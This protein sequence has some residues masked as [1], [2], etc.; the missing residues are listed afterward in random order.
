MNESF[1]R[2]KKFLNEIGEFKK[3][4]NI[5]VK[6]MINCMEKV[7]EIF[8]R[9]AESQDGIS[10]NIKGIVNSKLSQG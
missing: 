8:A 6:S 1:N 7:I 2:H 5:S 4:K 10:K 3:I 9:E